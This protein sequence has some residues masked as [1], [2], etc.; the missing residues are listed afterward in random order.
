MEVFCFLAGDG[1]WKEFQCLPSLELDEDDD[2]D[3]EDDEEDDD[4]DIFTFLY[5]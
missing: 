1:I 2:D 4:D 5:Y 3:E